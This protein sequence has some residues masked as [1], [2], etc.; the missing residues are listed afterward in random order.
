MGKGWARQEAKKNELAEAIERATLWIR[1]HEQAAIWSGLGLLGALAV[2][3]MFVYRHYAS[4]ED[5]W[6]MYAIAQSLAYSGKGDQAVQM[7]KKIEEEH[8]QSPAAGH[9]ALLMG[10]ML[11]QQGKY[12]EALEAYR[13]LSERTMDKALLPA[14]LADIAASQESAGDYK[15]AAESGQRFLDAYQDHF[16]AAQVHASLARCLS[17][18]GDA[19]KAKAAYERIVFLYPDSYWAQWAKERLKS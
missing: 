16:L 17:A 12:K 7:L 6:G 15:A 9:G 2:G 18:Q 3:G 11:F 4:L 19:E 8:P 1:Y 5:T 13:A 10:D 14:V